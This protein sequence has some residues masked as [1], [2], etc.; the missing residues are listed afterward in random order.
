MRKELK[1]TPLNAWHKEHGGQMVDFAAGRCPSHISEGSSKNTWGQGGTVA[2]SISRT[3]AFF[4][5]WRGGH[6]FYAVCP[7][8][9]RAGS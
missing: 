4:N 5:S 3:W 9:Q 1:K 8:E 2:S 7:H 6:P